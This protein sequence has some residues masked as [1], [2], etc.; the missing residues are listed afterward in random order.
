MQYAPLF[1]RLDGVRTVIIGGGPIAL[2]KAETFVEFG[3]K[4]H[5]VAP[6][7]IPE[8]QA[9][10]EERGGSFHQSPY[11]PEHL[12]GAR[13][14]IAATGDH[15][16][17]IRIHEDARRAGA[18]VNV[19]DTPHLCD[20]IFPA[21]VRRGDIQIAV[22]TAGISPTLAR[23][24]KRR[25]E[26]VVPWNLHLLAAWFKEKRGV[27]AKTFEHLQARR[28]FWDEIIEGPVTQEILEG[29]YAKAED[30]F[31]QALAEAQT[32]PR[33]ALYLIGAGPG[34]PDLI[35]VRAAQLLAQADVVLYDRLIPPDTLARYARKDGLKIPVG[36]SARSHTKTQEEI[37]AL[38]EHC[39]RDNKIV[40]RLKGGDPGIYAHAAEE[41]EIARRL[42][43]PYQIVPG[44]T[45]AAACAA[46]AGIPLTERG[47]AK[48]LR[49]L[50]LYDEDLHDG[51]FWR[52]IGL[53]PG[54]TLAFYMTTRQRGVLCEKL[55]EAGLDPLTP[56]VLIEQGATPQHAE[57]EATLEFF[58]EKYASH[59]FLTP[60]LLIVG[61]VV[62]H[63]ARLG[64][65]EP[66]RERKSWFETARKD[67]Q[68]AG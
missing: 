7:I 22:S 25:I 9:F 66:P 57:Y 46:A 38:I 43:V 37:D 11:A 56:V 31:A 18:I 2:A 39:L 8:L 62:R 52:S 47:G 1:F 48:G 12:A 53:A 20:F 24:L 64:W 63:R 44:I 42:N 45:A 19:V 67:V 35:T 68:H 60:S 54:E 33:A 15:D 58:N 32:A 13:I 5:I 30:L 14:V 17:N 51:D 23:Y 40:A 61:Q 26:Q 34:H 65:R 28:L 50:T 10:L 3:A 36:K 6:D 55:I 16:I 59:S 21:I 27:I 41:L 29:N 4:P 49:L